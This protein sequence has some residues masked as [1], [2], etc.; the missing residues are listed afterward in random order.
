MLFAATPSNNIVEFT[1]DG[2]DIKSHIDTTITRPT[3]TGVTVTYSGSLGVGTHNFI[4]KVR[5]ASGNSTIANGVIVVNS[6]TVTPVLPTI[7]LSGAAIVPA[8]SATAAAL[9][10]ASGLQVITTDA[11]SIT[12]NGS[13][14]AT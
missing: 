4:A 3:S 6:A 9:R 10:F 11:E 2:V 14:V 8:Y 7:T 1:L 5:D 12:I 13:S